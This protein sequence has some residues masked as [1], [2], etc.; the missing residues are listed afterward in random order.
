[1]NGILEKKEDGWFVRWSDLHSFSYGTH[2][3]WTPI[4]PSEIVDETKYKDGDEVEIESSG[5]KLHEFALIENA[6]EKG[7]KGNDKMFNGLMSVVDC[8]DEIHKNKDVL[9]TQNSKSLFQLQG[10]SDK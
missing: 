2:W 4:H 6:F 7:Y 8:L 5:Y 1:M 3:M 9:I 10:V